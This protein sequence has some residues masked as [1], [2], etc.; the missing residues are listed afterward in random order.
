M[1]FTFIIRLCTNIQWSDMLIDGKVRE[2][3]V[4]ELTREISTI[5]G[6]EEDGDGELSKF[7]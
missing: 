5:N 7:S 6:E 2:T 1:D 3:L 4:L